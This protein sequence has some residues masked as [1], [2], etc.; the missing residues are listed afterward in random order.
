MKDEIFWYFVYLNSDKNYPI[1]FRK[2]ATLEN[3][4]RKKRIPGPCI[5]A[6]TFYRKR[7]FLNR[8]LG[9][10][11]LRNEHTVDYFPI[12]DIG[13]IFAQNRIQT[14]HARESLFLNLVVTLILLELRAHQSTESQPW[15][16]TEERGELGRIYRLCVCNWLGH[17]IYES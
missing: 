9:Y 17:H 4:G 12:T 6:I 15:Y 3:V 1:L 10:I 11:F 5:P 13:Y 8:K 16:C 14:R 2:R 7:K